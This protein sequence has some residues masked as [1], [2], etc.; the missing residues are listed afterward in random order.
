MAVGGAPCARL[1]EERPQ[2]VI[3]LNREN[4]LEVLE[5]RSSNLLVVGVQAAK[6]NLQGLSSEDQRQERE[7]VREAL[8]G[9]ILHELIER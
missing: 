7:D 3:D 5:R 2:S 4:A 8:A 9:A 6:R 1:H